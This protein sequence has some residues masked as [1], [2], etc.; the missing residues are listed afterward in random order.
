MSNFNYEKYIEIV[1]AICY[2]GDKLKEQNEDDY[3]SLKVEEIA[4]QLISVSNSLNAYIRHSKRE[5]QK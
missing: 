2:L 5:N 1:D 3:K 4:C